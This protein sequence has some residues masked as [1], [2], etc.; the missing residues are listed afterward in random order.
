MLKSA[1]LE[2]MG[3]AHGFYRH[4]ETVRLGKDP[5]LP[6]QVHGS[7]VVQ[8]RSLAHRPADGLWATSRQ[9]VVM[10]V[11]TADCIPVLMAEPSGRVAAIHAGWRG[12]AGQIVERFLERQQRHGIDP[13]QWHIALGP[14][15]DGCCYEVGPE[16]RVKLDGLARKGCVD[17][18]ALLRQR[19]T[20][21]GVEEIET[22]GP[23]T[24]CGGS[25]WA[26]YR[27]QG[28]EAGRN[29]AAISTLRYTN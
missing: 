18:R 5:I 4:D 14:A 10:G 29:I 23:C 7:R 12:V 2:N 15:A 20:R 8:P 19:L 25:G 16:V 11:R 24:I 6:Q 26:S 13:A 28:A 3:I 22:V 27:R 17:L 21:K 1:L 9:H